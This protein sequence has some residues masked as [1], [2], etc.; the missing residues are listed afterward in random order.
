MF[1]RASLLGSGLI[2]TT[3]QLA[4]KMQHFDLADHSYVRKRQTFDMLVL[5]QIRLAIKSIRFFFP[6]G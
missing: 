6:S 5:L 1:M 2:A 3:F 4:C